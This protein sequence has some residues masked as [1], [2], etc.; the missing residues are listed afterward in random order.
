[1]KKKFHHKWNRKGPPDCALGVRTFPGNKDRVGTLW[2]RSQFK[3]TMW[4]WHPIDSHPFR[5]M[6]IGPPIPEIQYFQNLTLKIKGQGHGWGHSLKSQWGS[7]ILSTSI[8]FVPCQ[9]GIPFVSY[10]FYKIWPWKSKVKVMGEV[11]SKSQCGSSI[12]SNHI[13]FVPCQSA[14]PF[15]RYSIFKIWPWKSRVKVIGEVTAQSHN[16]GLTSYRLTSLSFHVNRPS[17]SWDTAFSKFDLE[18]QGSRSWV[19]SQF[20]VTMRV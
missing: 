16:V 6:L 2:V 7:N 11:S 14:L 5:S 17:H 9:S 12:L 19:R 10:D 4:V 1:M 15:F 3:V 18:N 13:L 8:P 20:E